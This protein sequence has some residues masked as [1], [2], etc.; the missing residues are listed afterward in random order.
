MVVDNFRQHTN[1]A[2]GDI[3]LHSDKLFPF[4]SLS[5]LIL[6]QRKPPFGASL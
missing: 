6:S 4:Y 3:E 5:G 2:L 1:M